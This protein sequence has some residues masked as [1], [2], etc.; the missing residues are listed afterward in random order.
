MYFLFLNSPNLNGAGLYEQYLHPHY[1]YF[2]APQSNMASC[3]QHLQNNDSI[4]LQ[5]LLYMSVFCA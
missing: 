1:P 5:F 2:F 4:N 3:I